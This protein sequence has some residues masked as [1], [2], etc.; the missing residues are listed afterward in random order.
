MLAAVTVLSLSACTSQDSDTDDVR[1]ALEE[2]EGLSR[3]QVRTCTNDFEDADFSQDELNDI[4]N[5]DTLDDLPNDLG[6]Q[7]RGILE[8]CIEGSSTT[9]EGSGEPSETSSTTAA[10]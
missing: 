10:P 5:A 6:E 9:D 7:V 8:Q 1:D 4:A 2:T 3:D